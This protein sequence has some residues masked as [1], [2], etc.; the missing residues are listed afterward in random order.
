MQENVQFVVLGNGDKKYEKMFTDEMA[1]QNS[2]T[3]EIGEKENKKKLYVEIDY[4]EPL[5]QRIYAASD[6]F[7]MPSLFEPCGLGQL[8]S[9]RYGTLPIVRE[10]GGL[11]DTVITYNEATGEGNGFRFENYNAHDMLFTIQRALEIYKRKTL[12]TKLVKAVMSCDN[13]WDIPS[14]KY[15]ELYDKLKPQL[16]VAE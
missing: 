6:F 16:E 1:A 9:M 15:M 13:S 8:I 11:K 12:R 10:T 7:L 14:G 3:S 2:Y 5:A 4:N